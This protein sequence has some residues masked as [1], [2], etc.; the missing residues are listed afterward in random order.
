MVSH[1]GLGAVA[2]GRE[3]LLPGGERR[4]IH[5][6]ERIHIVLGNRRGHQ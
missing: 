1:A 2:E 3:V 5:R 6:V 4:G